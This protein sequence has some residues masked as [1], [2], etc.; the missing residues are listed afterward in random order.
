MQFKHVYYDP[1][2]NY[3]HSNKKIF[4]QFRKKGKKKIKNDFEMSLKNTEV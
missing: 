4:I 3:L 1:I 2:C